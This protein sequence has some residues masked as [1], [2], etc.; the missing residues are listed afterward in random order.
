M[1]ASIKNDILKAIFWH[2]KCPR[3]D[4]KEKKKEH[5]S[6]YWNSFCY[7]P[8]FI[9]KSVTVCGINNTEKNIS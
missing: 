9:L 7:D 8:K 4:V 1:H 2:G 3:H 5:K 6:S